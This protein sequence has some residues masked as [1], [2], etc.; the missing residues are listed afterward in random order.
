MTTKQTLG[1]FYTTNYE[2]ILQNFSIPEDITRIIEPFAGNGDL[3]GFI[4]KHNAAASITCYDIDPKRD[5]IIQR[6]TIQNPPDYTGCFVITNP[7]YLARNKSQN[8]ELF[9]KYDVGDLYKCFIKELLTNQCVGGILI[10]PLNFWSSIRKNDVGL[11]RDF[12][13]VYNLVRMNIFEEQVF[14]DTTTTVC[15]FQFCREPTEQGGCRPP[16]DPPATVPLLGRFAS[17]CA[18]GARPLP[19]ES[20]GVAGGTAVPL[21]QSPCCVIYPSKIAIDTAMTETNNYTIGGEIYQL[22]TNPNYKITRLTS[23]TQPSTHIV[24]KCIDDNLNS[25]IRLFW[26]DNGHDYIDDTSNLT[27]RTYA[28][29]VVVPPISDDQQK[30]IIDD[31]NVF[32]REYR[33]RYNS[34][35]LTNYRESKD[36]ARKRISFDLVYKIVGHLL[37]PKN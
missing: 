16:Y 4:R 22:Q 7:P 34:L 14:D 6:D 27:A 20:R 36:I 33:T 35:F 24:A 1:Q 2:Y 30:K 13:R 11:R 31:F 29:L 15:A 18:E 19:H 10:I 3:V 28:T 23:T 21:Q 25:Q 17:I 5:Y 8:K 12:L 32:L 9:D 37:I 26:V